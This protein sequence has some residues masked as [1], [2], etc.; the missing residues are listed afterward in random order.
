MTRELLFTRSL[1]AVRPAGTAG[2]LRE[3]GNRNEDE[4]QLD[5]L[6]DHPVPVTGS[7]DL[8]EVGGHLRVVQRAA[9]HDRPVADARAQLGQDPVAD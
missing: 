3:F 4:Q 8:V 7:V 6:V 5:R 1:I 2:R 9:V